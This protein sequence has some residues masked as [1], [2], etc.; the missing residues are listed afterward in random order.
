[1]IRFGPE[2]PSLQNISTAVAANLTL[3][4]LMRQ[5]LVINFLSQFLF[6]SPILGRFQS[7]R[8]VQDVS[9]WT[10]SQWLRCYINHLAGHLHYHFDYKKKDSAVL[11]V[12]YMYVHYPFQSGTNFRSKALWRHLQ[13]NTWET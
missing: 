2:G 12:L 5:E 1:M 11:V 8:I 6:P 10:T 7:G 3:A 13:S 9:Y 4:V